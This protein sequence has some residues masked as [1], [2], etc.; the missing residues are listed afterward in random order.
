MLCF[1]EVVSFFA[2]HNDLLIFVV[3]VESMFRPSCGRIVSVM[4]TFHLFCSISFLA[5]LR[6]SVRSEAFKHNLRM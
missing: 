5:L 6:L 4:F 2:S 3:F 1:Q